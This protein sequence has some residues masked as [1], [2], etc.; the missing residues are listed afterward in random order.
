LNTKEVIMPHT[1]PELAFSN[2]ALLE[3]LLQ[4]M[5]NSDCPSWPG[6]DGLTVP[7][8]VRSYPQYAASGRVPDLS[9]LLRRHAQ[10]RDA[11]LTFFGVTPPNSMT[12]GD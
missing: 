9:S 11:I 6:A 3:V 10:L 1:R 4:Y 8:V 7:E 2:D 12:A 5:R